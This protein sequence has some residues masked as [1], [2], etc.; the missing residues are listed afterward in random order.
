MPAL[1]SV[2]GTFFWMAGGLRL[3]KE[4]VMS[5]RGDE[6][7]F[8]FYQDRAHTQTNTNYFV[9]QK[10]SQ[11]LFKEKRLLPVNKVLTIFEECFKI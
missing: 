8:F 2:C 6:T 7:Y 10:I 4:I 9:I 5:H 1:V 3:N 11:D